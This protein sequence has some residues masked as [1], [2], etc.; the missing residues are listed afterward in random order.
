MLDML[1]SPA[2]LDSEDVAWLRRD[3]ALE[4]PE[5]ADEDDMVA[6]GGDGSALESVGMEQRF[7]KLPVEREKEREM[8]R[9]GIGKTSREAK[10]CT[11][12]GGQEVRRRAETESQT[13][14][15]LGDDLGRYALTPRQACFDDLLLRVGLPCPTL[16]CKPRPTTLPTASCM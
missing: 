3:L 9:R 13:L 10:E 11:R 15:E 5:V 14:S 7:K 2:S 6:A 8:S 4:L 16:P 12:S 1:N